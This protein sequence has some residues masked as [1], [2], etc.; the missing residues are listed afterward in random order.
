M[1]DYVQLSDLKH[2]VCYKKNLHFS[3]FP[4]RLSVTPGFCATPKFNCYGRIPE[5]E[6]SLSI[7]L[8]P[9]YSEQ[10]GLGQKVVVK[11]EQN[12]YSEET[13]NASKSNNEDQDVKKILYKMQHPVFHVQED[14]DKK[15]ISNVKSEPSSEVDNSS[16]DYPNL[17]TKG[18]KQKKERLFKPV[19]RMKID[20]DT[21]D[22]NKPFMF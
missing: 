22:D 6:S 19:K 12:L 20:F 18:K 21:L 2:R 8:K 10:I 4:A 11:A 3:A 17:S 16:F 9:M 13:N 14:N 7:H 5:N 1:S 15:N